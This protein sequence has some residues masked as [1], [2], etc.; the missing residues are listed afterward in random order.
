ML[1]YLSVY[2]ERGTIM[3]IQQNWDE[4]NKFRVIWVGIGSVTNI[5]T[6]CFKL[7]GALFGILIICLTLSSHM[8]YLRSRKHFTVTR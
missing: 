1:S 3:E 6:V 7:S 4:C 5:G 2:R 8:R